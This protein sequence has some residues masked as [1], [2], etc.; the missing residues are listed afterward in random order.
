MSGAG[1]AAPVAQA[2]DGE[3]DK[4]GVEDGSDPEVLVDVLTDVDQIDDDPEPP[5]SDVFARLPPAA[6]EA[7]AGECGVEPG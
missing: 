2:K 6:D 1:G 3:D 5:I 4:T 7:E